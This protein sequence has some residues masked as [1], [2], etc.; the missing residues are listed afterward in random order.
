LKINSNWIISNGENVVGN[1]KN[2]ELS[3]KAPTPT[4]IEM[5]VGNSIFLKIKN[6]MTL[7]KFV[8]SDTHYSLFTYDS[9]IDMHFT[10]ERAVGKEKHT[11][12]VKMQVDWNFLLSKIAYD[13]AANANSILKRAD[14][15]DPEVSNIEVESIS[16]DMLKLLLDYPLKHKRWNV[17][18]D[19]FKRLEDSLNYSKL[20][21]LIGKGTTLGW[22]SEGNIIISDGKQCLILN[23]D[24]FLKILMKNIEL[25]IRK[26]EVSYYTL[27][28]LAW[29]IKLNLLKINR[30]VV[31]HLTQAINKSNN[32]KK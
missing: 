22:S 2:S 32:R 15:S 5:K 16:S 10:N 28:T 18:D 17:N 14:L 23:A 12:I 6:N 26:L 1:Q 11:P 20:N 19:F 3:G 4:P 7:I 27:G 9:T 24:K 31:S 29:L 21:D 30:I 25:S 8:G 13:F